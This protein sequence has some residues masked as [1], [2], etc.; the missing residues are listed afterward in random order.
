MHASP[1]APITDLFLGVSSLVTRRKIPLAIA[2]L[3]FSMLLA[4]GSAAVQFKVLHIE[5]GIMSEFSLDRDELRTT[6]DA[7]LIAIS[8]MDVSEFVETSGFRIGS[9][10]VQQPPS[11]EHAV[12]LTYLR[13][14][15]SFV[16]MQ[17][18]FNIIVMFCAAVFFL[19]LFSGGSQ[20]AYETARRLPMYIF[21]MCGLVIWMLVRSLIWIPLVGPAIALY[22]LPRLSLAPVF[23][24]S[25][26]A[27]VFQSLHLSMRRTSGHWISMFLRL[28]LI[29]IVAVLILWPMLI[30]VVGASLL[31]V[32]LGYILFLL[33]IIFIVAFQCA[34][35]TVL[36][37]MM[38]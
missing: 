34:G 28:A 17:L 20:S 3:S 19:L 29:G 22:M 4:V 18:L 38:A 1:R 31:S 9:D 37:V 7:D 12:G 26:E 30:F 25:G 11:G 6:V 5:N 24:A 2:T 13:R 33:A 23:L 8:E 15:S 27:G 14:V 21:P 10:A 16:F 32:K 36:A 35:L